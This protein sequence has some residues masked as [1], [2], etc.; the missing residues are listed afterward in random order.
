MMS[1]A[2]KDHPLSQLRKVHSADLER[3]TEIALAYIDDESLKAVSPKS[4]NYIALAFYEY[5]RNA[6]VDGTGWSYVPDLLIKDRLRDG[7]VK[8]IKHNRAM[9]WQ[10]YGEIVEQES[11]RGAV[12]QWLSDQLEDYL[13]DHSGAE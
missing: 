9:S 5:L 3:Y 8:V 7:T 6:V 11:R 10:P 2:H 1:V 12:I 4:T 13:F